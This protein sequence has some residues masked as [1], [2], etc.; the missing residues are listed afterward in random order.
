MTVILA[1]EKEVDS[2]AFL[3]ILCNSLKRIAVRHCCRF[4]KCL[5]KEVF[6][7]CIDKCG[8]AA[9]ALTEIVLV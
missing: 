9:K 1:A 6:L 7:K 8:K 5:S 2:V 4:V 3:T